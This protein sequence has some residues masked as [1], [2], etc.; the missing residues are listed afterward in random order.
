MPKSPSKQKYDLQK[1]NEKDIQGK[2][3]RVELR[4]QKENTRRKQIAYEYGLPETAKFF[5]V[6]KKSKEELVSAPMKIFSHGTVVLVDKTTLDLLLIARFNNF[7]DMHPE[8][9][10]LFQ[11]SISTFY[12]H[13]ISRG[14]V[15]NNGALQGIRKYGDM[16]ALGWR[17][18]AGIAADAGKDVGHYALNHATSHSEDRIWLDIERSFLHLP[19]AKDFWAE[20]FAT[21]SMT[22]FEANSKIAANGHVPSFD[23]PDWETSANDYSV[24]IN[25]DECNGVVEMVWNTQVKHFTLKSSTKNGLGRKIPPSKAPLTRFGS[26]CQVSSKLVNMGKALMLKKEKMSS[27]EWELYTQDRVKGYDQQVQVKLDKL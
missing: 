1:R 20:R 23:S 6:N 21:L 19:C 11:S 14:H 10:A 13:G 22:A 3:R 24:G 4:I 27:E 16:R 7:S 17:C 12:L 26:S 18:G 5:F 9:Y 25:F 2:K 15:T 8:L